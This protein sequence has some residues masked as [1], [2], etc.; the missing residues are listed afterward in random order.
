MFYDE[1]IDKA[2]T[3]SELLHLIY[4]EMEGFSDGPGDFSIHHKALMGAVGTALGIRGRNLDQNLPDVPS[5]IAGLINW[6]INSEKIMTGEKLEKMERKQIYYDIDFF[7][8]IK[9]EIRNHP[10]EYREAGKWLDEYCSVENFWKRQKEYLE[11]L[12]AC[13]P[14]PPYPHVVDTENKVLVDPNGEMVLRDHLEL[15]QE[16]KHNQLVYGKEVEYRELMLELK[17]GYYRPQWLLDGWQKSPEFFTTEW[18]KKSLNQMGRVKEK[19]RLDN[20]YDFL[21]A[22]DSRRLF[23]G[24]EKA[25]RIILITWLLYDPDSENSGLNLTK[26]E[27]WPWADR[28]YSTQKFLAYYVTEHSTPEDNK[29]MVR[30]RIAWEE[31]QAEKTIQAEPETKSVKEPK[32]KAEKQNKIEQD[33]TRIKLIDFMQQYCEKQSLEL[34]KC[35]RKSLNDAH[36]RETIRLPK[37]AHKWKPGQSKYYK[38]SDLKAKW[39]GYCEELPNLPKLKDT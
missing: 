23:I 24:L 16:S 32:Q 8:K 25:R 14:E 6:C 9:V 5:D 15:E 13:G 39:S 31:I 37:P 7:R 27:S 1:E 19:S 17:K 22:D 36:N 20:A 26:F 28:L 35:R 12:L 38:A 18:V 11:E 29:W 2:K 4:C 34:L 10:Q 3:P 30:V 33:D 21:I